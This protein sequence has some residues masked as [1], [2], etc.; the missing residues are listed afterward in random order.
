MTQKILRAD[1]IN[2]GNISEKKTMKEIK[3]MIRFALNER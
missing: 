2:C 3:E 1:I